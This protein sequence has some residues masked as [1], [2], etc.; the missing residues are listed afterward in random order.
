MKTLR[1]RRS[2][3]GGVTLLEIAIATVILIGM[4][5][6]VFMLLHTGTTLTANQIVQQRI[7]GE[8]SR[9]I[10]QFNADFRSSGSTVSPSTPLVSGDPFFDSSNIARYTSIRFS[11][12]T[13][14]VPGT[15]TTE[16]LQHVTYFWAISPLEVANDNIDND[17]NGLIDDG[18]IKRSDTDKNGVTTTSTVLH[19]ITEKGLAFQYVVSADTKDDVTMFVEIAGVDPE[20]KKAGLDPANQTDKMALFT[21]RFVSAVSRRGN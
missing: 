17:G 11:L 5:V 2:R 15:S 20:R 8:A 13:G 16:Y 9:F 12:P 19:N 3:D 18:V 7:A 6:V 4:I 1:A 10:E 21:Q 14:F